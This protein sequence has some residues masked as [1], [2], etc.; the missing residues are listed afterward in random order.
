MLKG[1]YLAKTDEVVKNED[2]PSLM[3][4]N[5]LGFLVGPDVQRVSMT[6]L[7]CA[8]KCSRFNS[9]LSFLCVELLR[10]EDGTKSLRFTSNRDKTV[11]GWR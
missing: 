6:P 11:A 3:C 10:Y 4:G 2:S 8:P 9:F 7:R 1:E 5:T